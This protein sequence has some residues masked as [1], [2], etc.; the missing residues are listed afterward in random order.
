MHRPDLDKADREIFFLNKKI[1]FSL[2]NPVNIE[3]EKQKVMKDKMYNPRLVYQQPTGN[4]AAAR[5]ELGHLTFDESI[6]GKLLHHKRNELLKMAYM[7]ENRVTAKF[8]SCSLNLYGRPG[9]ELVQKAAKLLE[10][11]TPPQNGK[12]QGISTVKK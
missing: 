10:L 1:R 5:K 9:K 11:E 4:N 6:L 7:L 3:K 2:V 8:T 12:Y